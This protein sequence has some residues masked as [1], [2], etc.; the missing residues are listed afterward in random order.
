MIE[1]ITLTPLK[2]IQTPNGDVLHALKATE[3]TYCGFGEAYFSQVKS[4]VVKGWKRHNVMTL[5]IIVPIGKIR[6]VIYDDREGSATKGQFESIVLS[7]DTNYQ[8]LTIAPGLWMAF[9]GLSEETSL[10]M[11]VIPQP[12]DDAEGDRKGIEEIPFDFSL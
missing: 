11:D 3:A 2:R 1:G 6:F 4:G 9:Q 8:R 7:P 10:L 12:H 5:N